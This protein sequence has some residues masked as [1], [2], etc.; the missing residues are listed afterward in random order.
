MNTELQPT[1][2]DILAF[3][4]GDATED[5]SKAMQR[6]GFWF[7][8]SPA[9]DEIISQRFAASLECA[10][11]GEFAAWDQTARSCLALVLLLDQFSRNIYRGMAEAFQHDL[12]ALDVASR[13]VAAGYL[14]H[15]S[16][17]EQCMF[18][19]PFEHSE[20]LSVQRA[21]IEL[22]EMVVDRAD[23]EWKPS[24]RGSLVYARRHLEII[25]RF[26]RFPHR[27]AA[28]GREPTTEERDYLVN[29]G[30]SFGQ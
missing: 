23:P 9:V 11:R 10:A 26:G 30:D 18:I 13:G 3:W 20:E 15:L 24:A 14:E 25:E 29:G 16:P 5:P 27:N 22:F 19:L 28:L 8:A 2:E 21:G 6:S 1:P 12:Q 17:V 7:E 4:F